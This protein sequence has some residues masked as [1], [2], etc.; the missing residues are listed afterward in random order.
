MKRNHSL[1]ACV[2]ELARVQDLLGRKTEAIEAYE[3]AAIAWQDAD[4]VL[5]PRVE[6]ARQAI[7]RLSGAED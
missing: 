1:L 2:Y 4:P 3:N 7:T 5:R 6:A